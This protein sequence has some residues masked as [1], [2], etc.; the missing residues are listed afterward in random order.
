MSSLKYFRGLLLWATAVVAWAATPACALVTS[1][2]ASAYALQANVAGMSI[3]G[4]TPLSSVSGNGTDSHSVVS[5]SVFP[6]LSTGI[7]NSSASSNVD[8]SPG[9][10]TAD[11]SSS[12]ATFSLNVPTAFGL[13]FD[14]LSSNSHV[15]G[16]AG[17]FSALGSSSIVNL[18]GSGLLSPLSS[19]TI[20][21]APNQM[22]LNV[23]GIE[24]IANRQTSACGASS[25]SMTTDALFIDVAGLANL[26]LASSSAQLAGQVPEPSTW[27]L[28]A[29]GL[30]G[31]GT[32][33][34]RRGL[35]FN[36]GGNLNFC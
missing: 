5:L 35:E 20:T 23:G 13:S 6:I 12:V 17:S 15:T 36:G 8:G 16:D 32:I 10:K 19:V 2:G 24:V 28:M 4:P 25:C 21:G 27:T 31:L 26:T 34:K 29:L 18:A 7:L 30:L 3:L 9:S 33:A 14:L 1:G 22:L 11:G